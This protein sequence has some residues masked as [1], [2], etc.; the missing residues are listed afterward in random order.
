MAN[1]FA[2]LK[3]AVKKNRQ[4]DFTNKSR[5]IIMV[6]V[7]VLFY[8]EKMRRLYYVHSEKKN[9]DVAINAIVSYACVYIL[10]VE[11]NE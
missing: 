11:Q 7:H 6:I 10:L 4:G 9:V 8:T 3:E 1:A 2:C 5:I